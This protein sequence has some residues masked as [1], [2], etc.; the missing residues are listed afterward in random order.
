MASGT[1][2][3]SCSRVRQPR[4]TITGH[5]DAGSERVERPRDKKPNPKLEHR[6]PSTGH[7]ASWWYRHSAPCCLGHVIRHQS[8]G[9]AS[10]QLTR[11]C[12]DA[13]WG[14]Q[15]TQ[16][17]QRG[18]GKT[19][20]LFLM[21]APPRPTPSAG[22]AWMW[23]DSQERA[24]AHSVPGCRQGPCEGTRGF[25]GASGQAPCVLTTVTSPAHS[26]T[27]HKA[28]PRQRSGLINTLHHGCEVSFQVPSW[29]GGL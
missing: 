26:E 5:T 10:Y 6:A 2:A 7:R 8:Q 20:R 1:Q 12:P 13:F 23:A 24:R 3:P 18:L 14:D 19:P 21:G 9:S 27:Q 11:T 29:W 16:P 15:P 22:P 28:P 17:L 25:Q 4:L